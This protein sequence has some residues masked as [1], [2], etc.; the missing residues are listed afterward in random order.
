M[1][2]Q[3]IDVAVKHSAPSGLK[4]SERPLQLKLYQSIKPVIVHEEIKTELGFQ[5]PDLVPYRVLPG[6]IDPRIFV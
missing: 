2:P 3:N 4:V 6:A 5:S 1:N